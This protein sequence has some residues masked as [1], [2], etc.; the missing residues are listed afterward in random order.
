MDMQSLIES[1]GVLAIA[2]GIAIYLHQSFV[3]IT[4]QM[5]QAMMA[6]SKADREVFKE[7]VDKLDKR[8]EQVEQTLRQQK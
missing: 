2:P 5:M 1:F 8:I 7:A 4:Q 3:K 6:E